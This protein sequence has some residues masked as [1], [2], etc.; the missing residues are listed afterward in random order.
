MISHHREPGSGS[1]SG[2]GSTDRSTDHDLLAPPRLLCLELQ[3]ELLHHLPAPLLQ[4]PA[5]LG[6]RHLQ[7][8]LLALRVLRD[9]CQLSEGRVSWARVS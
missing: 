3:V 1:G 9:A 5:F 8:T 4:H 6:R 2:S 7:L